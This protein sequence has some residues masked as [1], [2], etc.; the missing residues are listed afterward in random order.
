MVVT[1]FTFS[2]IPPKANKQTKT[3]N[4][5]PYLLETEGNFSCCN[6][7]SL[8]TGI[9]KEGL[10]AI[11][12]DSFLKAGNYS[13]IT[14]WL[15][16]TFGKKTCPYLY[17]H[18]WTASRFFQLIPS[19]GQTLMKFGRKCW[20]TNPMWNFSLENAMH[21]NSHDREMPKYTRVCRILSTDQ[22]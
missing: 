2:Q 8:G 5:K 15:K 17:Y 14:K 9:L 4:K 18:A 6:L 3:T 7:F 21:N 10:P 20:F 1:Y 19:F 11:W 22:Q 16:Y 12:H 13:P